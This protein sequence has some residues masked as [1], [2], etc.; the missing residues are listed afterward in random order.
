LLI[1]ASI[2][3]LS[4]ILGAKVQKKTEPTKLYKENN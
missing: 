2:F 4:E 1:N 3:M